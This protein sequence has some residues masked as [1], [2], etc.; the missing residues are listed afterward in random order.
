MTTG[1]RFGTHRVIE[2]INS[3][4]QPAWKLDNT[5]TLYDNEVLVEVETLNVNSISFTQ[6]Y[7]ECEGDV[8]KVADK[9]LRIVENRGKLHNPI[10]G[11]GG[12]LIGTIKQIGCGY[13]NTY[14]I[15]VGDRIVSLVSLSLTPIKITKIK[16]IHVHLAQVE[17]EAEAI[18]F[19]SSPMIKAPTDLPSWE[20]MAVL[21]EAGAPMRTWNLVKETDQVMIL[22]AGG[23]MGLLCAFAARQKLG[24]NGQIWGL[25]KTRQSYERIKHTQVFD[26]VIC[27]DAQIPM[28]AL[29]EIGSSGELIAVTIN[30]IN[31][32]GT[33]ALS[34]LITKDQGSVYF[35]NLASNC[36]VASLI[37]EGIGKDLDIYTYKGYT[38]GHAS[39]AI[40]L[41]RNNPELRKLLSSRVKTAGKQLRS[42]QLLPSFDLEPKLLKDIGLESYVFESTEIKHVLKNA[43]RVANY[44]C[45]VLITG[46]SG[47]GKEIFAQIT[48]KASSRCSSSLVEINC[49]SIPQ[50]LLEAE[51]FGYEGGAF[52]GAKSSGK[53]GIFEVAKSGTL[54][55]DEIGELPISL[56]VKLLR[57]IQEK[58]I[59][60]VG[61]IRPIK[62]NVRI[63]A[64][65]K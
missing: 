24:P 13:D 63:V 17:V 60:R 28:T 4:P 57:A 46:E 12:M 53:M 14:T 55:L 52:T 23:K 11:T 54:F 51:L 62:V 59:Y 47:V 10:T 26:K 34:V 42:K 50:N 20:V 45:T 56:Q 3:L 38:H 27:A 6:M 5:M 41:L 36:N 43:L 44:D 1:C 65:N 21:D 64:S 7:N 25:V 33:E 18:L 58:E 37:A 61:G 30:C 22:G 2:P 32:P 29:Q 31:L 35:A 9:L 49:G 48:H 8:E 16:E 19:Q 39:F 40:D 15:K